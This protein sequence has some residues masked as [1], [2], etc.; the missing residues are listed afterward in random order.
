MR[1]LRFEVLEPPPAI[2]SQKSEVGS[3][4]LG[5]GV[6]PSLNPRLLSGL[7]GAPQGLH[8]EPWRTLL[9]NM[10]YANRSAQN[11]GENLGARSPSIA[12]SFSEAVS[13]FSSPA[14]IKQLSTNHI[15]L[16]ISKGSLS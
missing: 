16:A 10:T 12:V 9:G 4:R 13:R 5:V 7:Q 2:V 1:D 14:Y 15:P 3:V 6:G 8:V 11:E